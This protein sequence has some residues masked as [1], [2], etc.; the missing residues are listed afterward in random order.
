MAGSAVLQ[1]EGGGIHVV[2]R[3]VTVLESTGSGVAGLASHGNRTAATATASGNGIFY[4]LIAATV[5]GL[6]VGKM[7]D[8]NFI[9]GAT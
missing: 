4:F 8:V 1:D 7:H 5:A 2:V 3:S 9:E 6:A